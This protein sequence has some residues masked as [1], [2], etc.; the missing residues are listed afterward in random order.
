VVANGS[1]PASAQLDNPE[2]PEAA[3]PTGP[4][5]H[6]PARPGASR[7]LVAVAVG[8]F[9]VLA[10]VA[11]PLAPVITHDTTVTWPKAG[12]TPKSTLALF[13]PYTPAEVHVRVPCPVVETAAQRGKPTTVVGTG[14]PGQ[15]TKGFAITT[16][17]NQVV[18][19][20]SGRE[21]LRAPVIAGQCAV[22]ADSDASGSTTRI[23]GRT[24]TLPGARVK[25]VALIATDLSANQANGTRV[26]AKT[27][28]WFENSPTVGKYALIAAQ[29]AMVATAFVLLA[30]ADR[31]RRVQAIR[32]PRRSPGSHRIVDL[33]LSGVLVVWMVLGPNTPDDG[34]ADT[35]VRN[36]LRIGDI[37]NY[38]R[39][40]N[41]SEAPFTLV[42]HLLE[43]VAAVS[44]SPLALRVPSV[45]AALVTW[46]V[47]SRGILGIVLPRHGHRTDVRVLAAVG[48]LCWWLPF[49]LGIRPE[50]FAALTITAVLALVLRSTS[51]GDGAGLTLLGLA[52]LVAGLSVAINP[53][54]LLALAPPIVLTAQIRRV[55]LGPEGTHDRHALPGRIALLACLASTG[56]VAMF[57]DQSLFG[58]GEATRLHNY[59]GPDVAWFQ[60]IQRYQFLLE[61]GPQGDAARRI[62]VLCTITLLIFVALLFSRGAR[63]LPGMRMAH[64]PPACLAIGLVLLWVTPSKWT[65]YFGALAGIGAATL[66]VGVVLGVV[67]ARRWSGDR[68]VL[69]QG[70]VGTTLTVLAA[71]LGFAGK[72][73]WFLHSLY[74]VPWGDGPV[75]PLNSPFPWVFLVGALL[76][77]S[78]VL[79]SARR[80]DDQPA[81]RMLIRM[82]AVVS[83]VAV[84]SMVSILLY[85][86]AVAPA[87]QSASY[88]IGRQNLDTLT[89]GSCGIADDVVAT[90]DTPGGVLKPAEGD[91]RSIGFQR[92][93]GYAIQFPP[94]EPAGTGSS[95]YLWGSLGDGSV[96]TGRLTSRWFGLPALSRSREVAVSVAGRTGDGNRL[97]LEFGSSAGGRVHPL[98]ERV[99]DDSYREPDRRP[100]YPTDHLTE[101]QPQDHPSW[102]TL[103]VDAQDIPPGADRVRVRAVDGTSDRGGWIAVTGPRIRDVIPLT[104][105]LGGKAPVLVDWSMTWSAPCLRRGMPRVGAG[106][107]QPPA[108]L[109]N[110]PDRLGFEGTAAYNRQVGGTFA[111][112]SELGR[113][114]E[115]PTRLLGSDDKPEYAEWGSLIAVTYPLRSDGYDVRTVPVSRWGWQGEGSA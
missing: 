93:T 91:D 22:A 97:A 106:L 61:F 62:P 95:A 1:R 30:R 73:N 89:G 51:R 59:Y 111:A 100:I 80:Q 86:F 18:V 83:T 14:L 66:T 68:T 40:E 112:V 33:A 52:A 10:A 72:N 43:P 88:S 96:A 27:G 65:H 19:A 76:V 23:G 7:P 87:R 107:A 108:F 67:A 2:V 13:V 17:G 34:F 103:R 101:V 21:V 113:R 75:R 90:P 85:S 47:L 81:R 6:R 92:G 50:P 98:G 77:A 9:G 79:A 64:V 105:Y 24:A 56:L 114:Q 25:N 5:R 29:L 104:T 53:V 28:D 16:G 82:P 26:S 36:G 11:L 69:R 99:L 3:R 15:P 20:L 44:E 35:T 42:Q 12:Q 31:R 8:V 32:P 4:E 71:A 57:A 58:A 49:G 63:R 54:G 39:W 110:P 60:E 48:F 102:R 41:A 70:L 74:G 115:I 38:Y 78:L 109:L 46:L 37:G 94:P 55:L 45:L 84:S